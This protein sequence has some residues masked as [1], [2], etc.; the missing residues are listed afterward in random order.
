MKAK[1]AALC[2]TFAP[3]TP[4][5][6]QA[7]GDI[8]KAPLSQML[9]TAVLE[10]VRAQIIDPANARVE[11]LLHFPPHRGDNGRVCGEV[12]E[13]TPGGE[14]I[15]AFYATYTRSGRVLRFSPWQQA[16]QAPQAWPAPGRLPSS[17]T[18]PAAAG[19]KGKVKSAAKRTPKK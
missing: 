7:P 18:A 8:A 16:A 6:A 15:R 3:I 13:Q 14:K 11:P 4:V 12:A 19:A 17:D 5:S 2:L 10:G 1:F 9:Q